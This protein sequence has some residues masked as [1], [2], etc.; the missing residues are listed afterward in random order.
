MHYDSS[1]AND[2]L[3]RYRGARRGQGRTANS[4]GPTNIKCRGDQ[5]HNLE[6]HT[7]KTT[8]TACHVSACVTFT[9]CPHVQSV[10]CVRSFRLLCEHEKNNLSYTRLISTIITGHISAHPFTQGNCTSTTNHSSVNVHPLPKCN[11]MIKAADESVK[12]KNEP[13]N[14]TLITLQ[15]SVSIRFHKEKCTSI[16]TSQQCQ[17]S[18]TSTMQ[19]HDVN[20]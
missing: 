13:A 19:R 16:T 20:N 7:A 17:C 11:P 12:K 6:N 2:E 8:F 14:A 3:G 5:T 9:A 1:R 10:S 4:T 15:Q 18:S